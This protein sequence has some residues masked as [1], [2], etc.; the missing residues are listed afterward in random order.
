MIHID[1]QISQIFNF[2]SPFHSSTTKD[3]SPSTPS[4]PSPIPSSVSF[5]NEIN[6]PTLKISSVSET[7]SFYSDP[8]TTIP[9]V[10]ANQSPSTITDTQNVLEQS[11]IVDLSL[12]IHP[13]T[14]YD[15]PTF[16][17]LPPSIYN[18]S[19]RSSIVSLGTLTAPRGSV[20]NKIV[21]APLLASPSSSRQPLNTTFR[22]ISNTR[23]TP[24]RS[25]KP[26]TRSQHNRS[27]IKH[28]QQIEKSTIIDLEPP[29]QKDT[30]NKNVPLLS[31]SSSVTKSGSNIFRRF[32]VD[33][34]NSDSTA[35]SSSALLYPPTSDDERP[36]SPIISGNDDDDDR[37]PL[38]SSSNKHHHQ[39]LL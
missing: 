27:S 20:S 25:P 1:E 4:H 6:I 23:Y 35:I 32:M 8:N 36:M 37:R 17:I 5:F 31:T 19:A 7:S 12:P 16:S 33:N 21:P 18:R 30:T 11:T 10:D 24:G 2:L 9:F 28:Q 15:L 13:S 39:T 3:P 22:P 26:K 34:T 14:D 38:T 29:L